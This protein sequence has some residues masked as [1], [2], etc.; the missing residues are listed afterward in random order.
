MNY[1][2]MFVVLV[3]PIALFA[4]GPIVQLIAHGHPY[5]N[6]A[7]AQDAADADDGAAISSEPAV[8]PPDIH[9]PW[10][11]SLDDPSLGMIGLVVDIFQNG[12]KLNGTIAASV[13]AH[14]TFKGN[15]ASDGM[16]ITLKF[17]QKHHSCRVTFDG[18]LVDPTDINGTYTSKHC[19]KLSSG[20]FTL[21]KVM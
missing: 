18:T 3:F 16:T 20:T 1:K 5:G 8:A 21:G 17:K 6:V 7:C 19:G 10:G 4:S 12:S 15:I 2:T 13:N 14:G 9:G 11:G